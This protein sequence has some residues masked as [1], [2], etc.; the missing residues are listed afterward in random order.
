MTVDL[1]SV[2]LKEAKR[3]LTNLKTAH[4]RGLGL[5]KLYKYTVTLHPP[6]QLFAYYI[7]LNITFSQ[8]S[9]PYPFIQGTGIIL[10]DY[11]A[12]SERGVEYINAGMGCL[13]RFEWARSEPSVDTVEILS[14][15]NIISVTERWW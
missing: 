9:S 7:E 3:E 13:M 14:S 10:S 1:L 6:G 11:T 4:K 2:R 12:L 5:L 15:A 8:N